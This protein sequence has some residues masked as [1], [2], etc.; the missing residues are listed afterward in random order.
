[1]RDIED[2]IR[3]ADELAR[4]EQW[5]AAAVLYARA[6]ARALKIGERE[7]SR[8]AYEA[9]GEAWR[10]DDRPATAAEALDIA[11]RLTDVPQAAA[12]AR[13]RLAGVLGEIGRSEAALRA[14]DEAAAVASGAVR[15]LAHDTAIDAS[16]ALGRV[17]EVRRRLA[18]IDPGNDPALKMALL[19][20][21]GQLLRV[22]GDLTDAAVAFAEV[23]DLASGRDEAR[24]ALAA[25]E[26]EMGEV[27]ALRG[28]LEDAIGLYDRAV[29]RF[30]ESGRRSSAWRAAAGRMRATVDLGAEV[31]VHELDAGIAHARERGMPVL[32]IDL[33]I[34]RGLA[35]ARTDAS[36][37]H[38]DLDRAIE[39]AD[40]L[41]HR[42]RAGRA[43]LERANR[44]P[45]P[46]PAERVA[47]LRRAE[48][49]LTWNEPWHQRARL[50]LAEALRWSDPVESGTLAA[51]AAARF[52]AME[53]ERDAAIAR[54]L[55]VEED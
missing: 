50:A 25:T 39:L 21:E 1:M 20:R 36:A 31:L 11:I 5:G 45:P 7:A 51:S 6:A 15:V 46:D 34:A 47:M 54:K 49:E 30:E 12:V 14:C 10:R 4:D 16:Y 53:M 43:R 55:L 40:G 29:V 13:I 27:A 38:A 18:M 23:E 17:D 41:S 9:A 52:A 33:R 32:E 24:P 2:S 28:D 19:F 22:S 35:S 44:V 26:A 48:V 8:T 42:W 3:R 37:A